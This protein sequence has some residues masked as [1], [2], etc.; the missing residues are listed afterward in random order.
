M[1]GYLHSLSQRK[2][3][4]DKLKQFPTPTSRRAH[5]TDS[6]LKLQQQEP[7]I[8]KRVES[9]GYSNPMTVAGAC[10]ARSNM[11]NITFADDCKK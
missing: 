8:M 2:Y 6:F 5:S 7:A 11:R 10:A 9:F 1:K 4:P 3:A